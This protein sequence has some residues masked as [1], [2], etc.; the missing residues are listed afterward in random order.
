MD[1]EEKYTDIRE[2]LRSLEQVKAGDDFIH[3]LNHKIVELEAGK[4]TEHS[5]KFNKDRGGFLRNLFANRQNPWLIPAAGFTILIFFVL[6]IT[7]LNKNASLNN[8]DL[9]STQKSGQ[10]EEKIS[11]A[12]QINTNEKNDFKSSEMSKQDNSNTGKDDF[13]QKDLTGELKKENKSNFRGEYE[14]KSKDRNNVKNNFNTPKIFA[15]NKVEQKAESDKDDIKDLSKQNYEPEIIE[16]DGKAGI[17]KLNVD[18]KDEKSKSKENPVS[19]ATKE[20]SNNNSNKLIEKLNIINK[21]N[22]ENL[23]DKVFNN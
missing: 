11:P 13:N 5:K 12:P 1:S 23:R 4:R 16:N 10:T 9:L 8:T 20:E 17:E 21:T 18:S 6:Y 15:Q 3:K 2:K 7:Y 22:L 19:V 14:N